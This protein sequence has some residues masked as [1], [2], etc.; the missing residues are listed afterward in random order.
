MNTPRDEYNNFNGLITSVIFSINRGA[1]IKDENVARAL[2]FEKFAISF[3]A[4]SFKDDDDRLV[5]EEKIESDRE[6]TEVEP[7]EWDNEFRYPQSYAVT[8]WYR[9]LRTKPVPW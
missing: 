8:L 6:D 9:Y 4:G 1:F 3:E 7:H 2:V 5:S